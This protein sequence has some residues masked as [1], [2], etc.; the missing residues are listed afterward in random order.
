MMNTEHNIVQAMVRL[1]NKGKLVGIVILM[2]ILVSCQPDRGMG[3]TWHKA[4]VYTSEGR[5]VHNRP[6]CEYE[7]IVINNSDEVERIKLYDTKTGYYSFQIKSD[8]V[9]IK[10]DETYVFDTDKSNYDMSYGEVIIKPKKT[11]K[12]IIEDNGYYPSVFKMEK[13]GYY[14]LMNKIINESELVYQPQDSVNAI[15]IPKQANF[16]IDTVKLKPLN[17]NIDY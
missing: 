13:E 9:G 17:P 11:I 3:M 14:K 16:R 15:I 4:T 1:Q 6:Y 7:L 2:L 5:S 10:F 8:S 12:I